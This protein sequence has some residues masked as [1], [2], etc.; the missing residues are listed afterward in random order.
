MGLTITL[1]LVM[2]LAAAFLGA[3]FA[4]LRR[5]PTIRAEI[6]LPSPNVSRQI[7]TPAPDV[8]P[9]PEAIID[10]IDEE[11]EEHARVSRRH[12]AR[13]LFGEVGDWNVVLRML[14]REDNPS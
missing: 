7:A 4:V 10:Y 14:Q 8:S 13:A 12:R 3:F 1:I 2:L 5:P 9:I 11:S 6:V